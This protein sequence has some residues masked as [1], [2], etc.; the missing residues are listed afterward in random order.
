MAGLIFA[1]AFGLLGWAIALD[2][3]RLLR[4]LGDRSRVR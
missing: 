3:R 4:A 2:A 1:I